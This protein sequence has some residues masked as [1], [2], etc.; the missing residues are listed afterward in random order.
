MFGASQLFYVS[1][2][3][4]LLCMVVVCLTPPREIHL[5]PW[6]CWPFFEQFLGEI[7]AYFLLKKV[8]FMAWEKI[9]NVFYFIFLITNLWGA[10]KCFSMFFSHQGSENVFFFSDP[11]PPVRFAVFFWRCYPGWKVPHYPVVTN[12]ILLPPIP[13]V[14]VM[15][16]NSWNCWKHFLNKRQIFFFCLGGLAGAIFPE[17]WLKVFLRKLNNGSLLAQKKIQSISPK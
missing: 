2:T 8:F 4:M 9:V 14:G 7:F 12:C 5:S 13:G 11:D 15:G 10:S 3:V 1:S 17:H 16:S 6:T